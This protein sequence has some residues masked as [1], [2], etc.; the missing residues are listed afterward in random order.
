[1]KIGVC[2]GYNDVSTV[3]EQVRN[4]KNAGFNSVQLIARK[5]DI[6]T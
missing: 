2:L 5:H 1:M 3:E 6:M 4:V